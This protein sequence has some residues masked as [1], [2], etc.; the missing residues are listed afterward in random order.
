[1]TPLLWA[2]VLLGGGVG[3]VL[4]ALVESLVSRRVGRR[5]PW[6][7]LVVNLSG[8]FALGVVAGLT[9]PDQ[10][11]LLV[12]TALIGSYTTYS[13]WMLDSYALAGRS[14]TAAVADVV[15]SLVLGLAAVALGHALGAAL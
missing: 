7:I 1:M 3:A 6:G 4:R 13:T 11:H 15:G 14:R 2:G 8:A 12:G 9:L 10:A 5:F